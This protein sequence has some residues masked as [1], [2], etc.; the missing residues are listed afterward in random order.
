MAIENYE[1]LHKEFFSKGFFVCK[2]ILEEKSYQ[3]YLIEQDAGIHSNNTE[4]IITTA[5]EESADEENN[6][7]SAIV[8]NKN[9]YLF[10][11]AN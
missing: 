5:K 6:E 4:I 8:P 7:D 2:N 10:Y 1:E 9:T 11:F 3:E